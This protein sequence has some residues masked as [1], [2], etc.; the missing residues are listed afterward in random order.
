[1][2]A[3]DVVSALQRYRDG[4]ESITRKELGS[5]LLALNPEVWDA[6]AIDSLMAKCDHGDGVIKIEE[7]VFWLFGVEQSEQ[8]QELPNGSVNGL[9]ENL[10]LNAVNEDEL[11]KMKEEVFDFFDI[12][13]DGFWN[14][15]EAGY[16]QLAT[17][18]S[19][20]TM[21]GYKALLEMMSEDSESES[22]SKGLSKK[23]VL[24]MYGRTDLKMKIQKDHHMIFSKVKMAEELFEMFDVDE[25]G[26]WDSRET[27]DFGKATSNAGIDQREMFDWLVQQVGAQKDVGLS[28]KDVLEIYTS[29]KYWHLKMDVVSDHSKVGATVKLTEYLFNYYVHMVDR[30]CGGR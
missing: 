6:A 11:T 14:L 24:E 1:M 12:D 5:I 23:Q 28:K 29:P 30:P 9:E 20:L 26:F 15:Q 18:G 2:P 10:T 27:G 19:S 17:E 8:L 21:A 16:H 25:D 7:F 4:K 3:A 13:Q 22:A